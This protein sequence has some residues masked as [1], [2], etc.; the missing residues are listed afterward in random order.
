MAKTSYSIVLSITIFIFKI[1]IW[2]LKNLKFH[3]TGILALI[4]FIVT[5]VFRNLT[6]LFL[7]VLVGFAITFFTF[8]K[9]HEFFFFYFIILFINFWI[10]NFATAKLFF[11][12]Q[13]FGVLTAGM[14]IIMGKLVGPLSI[15]FLTIFKGSLLLLINR[16]WFILLNTLNASLVE[17]MVFIII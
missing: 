11:R 16:N 9:T 6:Q 14:I 12:F 17:W 8:L 13:S 2:T 7:C 15:R 10:D 3:D 1:L 4:S 5:I